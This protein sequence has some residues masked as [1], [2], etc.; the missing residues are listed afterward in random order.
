MAGVFSSHFSDNSCYSNLP[1]ITSDDDDK[2]MMMVILMAISVYT[3]SLSSACFIFECQPER[4]INHC[5][6]EL[7]IA[8]LICM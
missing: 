3:A 5:V 7:G 2:M 1:E 6:K 4:Q 8:Q